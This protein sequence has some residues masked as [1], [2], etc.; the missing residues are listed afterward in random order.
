M[1]RII[2]FGLFLLILSGTSFAE[3]NTAKRSLVLVNPSLKERLC[4][5]EYGYMFADLEDQ[6]LSGYA[7]EEPDDFFQMPGEFEEKREGL[8]SGAKAA[9]LSLLLPGAG[10]IYGGSV[11]KGKVF[12][13]SEA[14]LWIGFF[15]F[16]TYG[17]W[18]RKDYKVYA[19]SHAKVNLEGKSDDYFDQ[20]AFYDSRD[21]Y[22]QYAPLY[23]RENRQPYP[24]DEFWNWEWDSRRSRDYYRDLKNRSK[25]A[26]RN[27]LYI[28]GLSVLNRI[29]SVVDAM[30]TVRTYN[31]K[32]SLEFS[33]MKFDLKANLLAQNPTVM[34]Y[35]TR[36]W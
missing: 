19:A 6:S 2:F 16:R 33:H 12:M 25:N 10:E 32:K 13:F 15:G 5:Q 21:Q 31:R 22:N 35:I 30:K 11:G 4:C 34:L 28:V 3:I 7:S 18:L 1:K 8:K 9:L 23:Y 24:E 26:S 20:L 14:A 36:R 17:D 27:A 29:I